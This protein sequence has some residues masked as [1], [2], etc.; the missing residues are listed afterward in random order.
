MPANRILS[1]QVAYKLVLFVSLGLLFPAFGLSQDDCSTKIQ[2]ARRAYDQ[3]LIEEVPQMLQ[4]CM[5]N[6]FSRVQRIEAYKLMILSYLFD[7]DQFQA[8]KTMVEFLKKFPEYEINPNDPIE[9]V[10]LF[11]SYRTTSVF[12]IGLNAGFN[13]TDPRIIEPY[14]MLDRTHAKLTN[15]MKSG[16]QV[17]LGVGTYLSKHILANVELYFSENQY[18]FKDELIAPLT[19]ASDGITSVLY[20]EKLLKIEIPLTFTYEFTIKKIHYYFRGGASLA[21]LANVTGLASRRYSPELPPVAGENTS[22]MDSRK[23]MLYSG[24]AGFGLRYKV[25]RGVVMLDF[26]THIGL[27]NIVDPSKRTLTSELADKFYHRDDDYSLN[28]F[29]ISAGYYFSFYKPKKREL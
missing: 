12:S 4:P 26:R 24:I 13:F 29:S 25:P 5:E 23:K 15:T 22:M 18:S 11:E 16:F 19:G 8:E 10:Y 28:S 9:F 21:N 6:G 1:P 3:G 17:G 20:N 27:N 2:D 7:D 14:T